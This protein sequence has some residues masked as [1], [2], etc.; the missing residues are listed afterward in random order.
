LFIQ[1]RLPEKLGFARL[2]TTLPLWREA[3][4]FVV[5]QQ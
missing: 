5:V 4:Q 2:K 3:D 1:L